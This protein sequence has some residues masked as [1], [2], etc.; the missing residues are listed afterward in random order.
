MKGLTSAPTNTH[1]HKLNYTLI[2]QASSVGAISEN[3]VSILLGQTDPK[4]NACCG[5]SWL[6]VEG[7]GLVSLTNCPIMLGHLTLIREAQMLQRIIT[8]TC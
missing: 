1:T 2:M 3:S 8:P 4:I 6:F 5:C 7:E